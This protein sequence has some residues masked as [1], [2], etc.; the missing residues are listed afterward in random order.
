MQTGNYPPMGM[1]GGQG[2]VVREIATIHRTADFAQPILPGNA[3]NYGAQPLGDSPFRQYWQVLLKRRWVVIGCTVGIVILAGLASLRLP[4]IYQS[5]SRLAISRSDQASQTLREGNAEDVIDDAEME[6]QVRI[7]QS[8]VLALQVIKKLDLVHNPIYGGKPAVQDAGGAVPEIAGADAVEASGVLDSFKSGLKVVR[9]PSTR[10]V[11]IQYSSTDPQLASA[12]VNTTASAYVEQNF[13]TKFEGTMQASDWLSRQ[14]VDL[15]MRVETAQVKLVQY[16]KDHEI[17]GDEKQNVVTAKLDEINRELTLAQG[18]RIEKEAAYRLAQS[19]EAPSE[20]SITAGQESFMDKLRA[21]EGDLKVQLAKLSSEFGPAYPEVIRLSN[22]LKQVQADMHQEGGRQVNKLKSSYLAAAQREQLLQAEFEE[23]KQQYNNL[24]ESFIE[25]TALKRDAETSQQLYDGLLEKLK[26]A[27]V[28]AGLRSSGI[29]VVDYGRL[30]T[31]PSSPNIP[32]NLAFALLFGM[33]A[34][35]GMAFLLESLDNTVRTTEEAQTISSLPALGMIPLGGALQ[36]NQNRRLK[37]GE[38]EGDAA[39]EDDAAKVME[40]AGLITQSRPQSQMAESYRALRTSILLSS[41]GGP[42]RVIMVTS[43]L[44]QEGKTTTSLNFATVLAQ[45]ASRV[46]LIDADLRRPSVHTTLGLGPRL[47]LSNVLSGSATLE[48]TVIRVPALKSLYVLPAGTT[49]PNPAEMLASVEMHELVS[50]LR[51]QYD[52]IVIDT[53]P[54]LSVTD[55]A[56][57]SPMADTVVLVIRA[58]QTTKQ[59]LKRARDIL[60]QVNARISG[61]V[62]NAVDLN[63]P[64]YQYYGYG[65]KYAAYYNEDETPRS[66]AGGS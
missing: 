48:S 37:G 54:V 52:H 29:R 56:V 44:P 28:T 31:S 7:I 33:M 21:Q 53:P 57:V 62:L 32:R 46:L 3:Y 6:T 10:L 9:V 50:S 1:P 14:L 25:Y 61:V 26:E 60:V 18:E 34:G 40:P 17:L 27:G 43:S 12:V 58:G 39:E 11:E 5:T 41:I 15:Q 59:A 20:S 47:G 49:P 64:G 22:Q 55:A 16:Q 45:K 42:P 30:P 36:D 51:K 8:D 63:A 24:N 65:S 2:P 38:D 35:V 4:K 19:G 13:K 23:Q 66:S